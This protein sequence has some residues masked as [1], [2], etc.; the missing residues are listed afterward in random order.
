MSADGVNGSIS[1]ALILRSQYLDLPLD[2][3]CQWQ[4]IYV[5]KGKLK[6]EIESKK[7][8]VNQGDLLVLTEFKNQI[9]QFNATE[10]CELIFVDIF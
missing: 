6:I 7:F 10:N 8:I 4:F 1:K 5:Y 3:T 2:K 9:L